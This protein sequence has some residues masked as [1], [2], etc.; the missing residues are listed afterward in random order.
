M[1]LLDDAIREHLELKRVRGADPG[2]VIREEREALGA[3]VRH[4][5]PTPASDHQEHESHGDHVD[6]DVTTVQ[7]DWLEADPADHGDESEAP[8]DAAGDLATQSH[9]RVRH[10]AERTREPS[11]RQQP[12]IAHRTPE[13][14]TA[15]V[16]MQAMLGL[17]D[18]SELAREEGYRQ[19]PAAAADPGDPGNAGEPSGRPPSMHE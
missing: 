18:E 16:D 5:E 3:S 6:P 9:E 2:E 17:D 7:D 14:D 1:G 15:E 11:H 8:G 12:E 19:E 10:E 13:Q 4:Q